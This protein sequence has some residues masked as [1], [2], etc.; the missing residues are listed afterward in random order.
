MQIPFFLFP[1][2]LFA[3]AAVSPGW[4]IYERVGGAGLKQD[5]FQRYPLS[6]PTCVWL[7][8]RFCVPG[9]RGTDFCKLREEIMLSSISSTECYIVSSTGKKSLLETGKERSS[10]RQTNVKTPLN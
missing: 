1:L 6:F 2:L 10:V 9:L 8:E 4:D 5:I 3:P 7:T